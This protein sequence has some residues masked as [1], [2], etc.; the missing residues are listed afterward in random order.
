VSSSR[1]TDPT[2]SP[3]GHSLHRLH[4]RIL[5]PVLQSNPDVPVHAI[6]TAYP[7]RRLWRRRVEIRLSPPLTLEARTMSA[8]QL[9]DAVR[10]A[11]LALG[12]MPYV[13]TY[14]RDIKA[15]RAAPGVDKPA[16]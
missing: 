16:R 4:K 15:A 12:G 10:D 3:D 7:G 8:D 2:R 13:D 5:V 11:L 9:T 6:T 1:S 14:A